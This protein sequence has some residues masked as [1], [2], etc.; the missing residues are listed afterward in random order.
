MSL[1]SPELNRLIHALAFAAARHRDQRRKDAQASPYINHLI[2]VLDI[3]WTTGGVRNGELLTAAVLHD[4][5]EDTHTS[6]E[7]IAEEFGL[8]VRALVLELSDDKSLPSLVRKQ[9]QIKHA[10]ALSPESKQIKLADK[11]SNVGDMAFSP[12]PDWPWQRKADYLD[13][14]EK[15]VAGLRGANPA[16]EARFDEVLSAG[17]KALE[18]EKPAP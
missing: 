9:L 7:E 11:I 8:K 4:T 2:A 14:A 13:W 17:R 5:L 18:D 1:D 6:P 3:L 12:P 10:P 16:M 15:V